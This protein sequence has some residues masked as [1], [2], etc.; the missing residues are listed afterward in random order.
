MVLEG[1]RGATPRN[2]GL[3][4]H[5]LLGRNRR[6]PTGAVTLCAKFTVSK[7]TSSTTPSMTSISFLFRL[8]VI[9]DV[10]L[11]VVVVVDDN[12]SLVW[13]FVNE[14]ETCL[15]VSVVLA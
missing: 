13:F 10:V 3:G 7:A 15:R 2:Q 11:A 1:A 14:Y 5:L 8:S 4:D 12:K 9:D 6:N